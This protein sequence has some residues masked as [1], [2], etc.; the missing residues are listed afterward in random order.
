[1]KSAMDET[2]I[3]ISSRKVLNGILNSNYEPFK[4]AKKEALNRVG[5]CGETPAHI[6]IYTGDLN[7]LQQCLYSEFDVN[8]KNSTGEAIYHVAAKLGDLKSLKLIYETGMSDLWQTT[9]ENLTAIEIAGSKVKDRD[10]SNMTLF[11]EWSLQDPNAQND[12]VSKVEK[13]VKSI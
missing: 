6:S 3:T 11:K 2:E 5:T 9:E 12:V 13:S 4:N 7:M 8:M 1:M 10:L